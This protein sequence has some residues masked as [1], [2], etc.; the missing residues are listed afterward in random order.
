MQASSLYGWSW[1]DAKTALLEQNI[2]IKNA[3]RQVIIDEYSVK[4]SK[5]LFYPSISLRSG[6]ERFLQ[7]NATLGYRGFVGPR[8]NW[9]VY[10]GGERS[11]SRDLAKYFLEETESKLHSNQLNKLKNLKEIFAKILYLK[12]YEQLAKDLH[13]RSEENLRY[14]HLRYKSGDEYLWAYLDMETT[15]KN[16]ELRLVQI[17]RDQIQVM[18]QLEVLLGFLPVSNIHEIEDAGFIYDLD[19]REEDLLQWSPTNHPD[20]EIS[21][22]KVS[23]SEMQWKLSKSQARPRLSFRTDF[24]LFRTDE[25]PYIPFLYT[26]VNFSMPLFEVGRIRRGKEKRLIA[27]EQAQSSSEQMALTLKQKVLLEFEDYKIAKQE[28]NV[29]SLELESTIQRNKIFR[30]QYQSG[31]ID[32][33]RW[34]NDEK[35]LQNKKIKVLQKKRDLAVENASLGNAM[36]EIQ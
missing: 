32:F 34:N 8:L 15:V 26:G 33:L 12:E 11:Y 27:I 23:Q 18:Q 30:E 36:G 22:T 9:S 29:A 21:R 24:L 13:R 10:E 2:D 20:Y 6:F 5:S 3:Q 7:E 28:L 17:Q 1:Q 19:L 25:E 35:E 14:V 16:D 4:D 31:E